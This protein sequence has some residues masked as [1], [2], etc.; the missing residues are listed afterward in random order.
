MIFKIIFRPFPQFIDFITIN[1]LETEFCSWLAVRFWKVQL[2]Y[3]LFDAEIVVNSKRSIFTIIIKINHIIIFIDLFGLRN[4][5]H[6]II[7]RSTF[8]QDPWTTIINICNKD[9]MLSKLIYISPMYSYNISNPIKPWQECFF[10]WKYVNLYKSLR[11][12]SAIKLVIATSHL[13]ILAYVM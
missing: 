3:F 7:L 4:I 10:F 9:L 13:I 6:F 1:L 12:R 11:L 2:R 5:L 8:E